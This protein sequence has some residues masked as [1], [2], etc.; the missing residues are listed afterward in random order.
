MTGQRACRHADILDIEFEVGP[1][2]VVF[3][4]PCRIT[5]SVK[6]FFHMVNV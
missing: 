4:P 5:L 6:H 1:V 2:V 3:M